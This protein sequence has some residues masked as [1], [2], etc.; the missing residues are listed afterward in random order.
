MSIFT[1]ILS[2]RLRKM[3]VI[4]CI[5]FKGGSGKTT[6]A[7]NLAYCLAKRGKRVLTLDYDAQSSLS[8]TSNIFYENDDHNIVSLLVNALFDRP[9][10]AENV[11]GCIVKTGFGYD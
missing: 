11:R 1:H 10:T 9:I 4:S 5:N 7:S 3:K 6:T 8:T 2:S